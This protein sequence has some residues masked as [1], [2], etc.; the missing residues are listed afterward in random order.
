ME[1]KS[2]ALQDGFLTT[3]LLEKSLP[4][5]LIPFPYFI[6]F[7]SSYHYLSVYINSCI[8]NWLWAPWGQDPISRILCC[9][10]TGLIHSRCSVNVLG[11]TALALNH[12]VK[13]QPWEFQPKCGHTGTCMCFVLFFLVEYL[14]WGAPLVAY[15]VKNLPT[16]QETWV[17]F[18]GWE[19]SLDLPLEN[20]MAIHSSILAWKIPWTEKPGGLWSMGSQSQIRL[21]SQHKS[22]FCF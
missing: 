12:T 20:G 4:S 3:G 17:Q 16:V 2:P 13:M 14:G 5:L 22:I 19:D 8:P 10:C 1:P 11:I 21:S 6:L 15:T 9:D 7:H 18:L